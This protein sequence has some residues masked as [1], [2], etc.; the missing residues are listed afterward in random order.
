MTLTAEALSLPGRLSSVSAEFGPG[1]VT[2]ICGPNGRRQV[3]AACMSGGLAGAGGGE[4]CARWECRWRAYARKTGPGVIGYLPQVPEIAWDIS[5]E[6]LVSLGA[7]TLAWR[8]CRRSAGG[9]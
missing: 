8:A 7:H 5:I 3:D 9:G 6:T 1:K 2:A 4:R